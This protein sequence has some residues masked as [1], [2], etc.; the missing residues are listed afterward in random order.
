MSAAK[1]NSSASANQRPNVSRISGI[2]EPSLIRSWM[3][4][5]AGSHQGGQNA[6]TNRHACAGIHK[7]G[8]QTQRA[9]DESFHV[10]NGLGE[11]YSVSKARRT[12]RFTSRGDGFS[13]F[14]ECD[15]QSTQKLQDRKSQRR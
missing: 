5:L 9:S 8:Q 15:S 3:L 13:T 10:C 14:T 11:R 6:N 4:S 1:A 7:A 2:A 12:G